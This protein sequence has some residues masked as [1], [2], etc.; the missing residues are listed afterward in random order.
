MHLR[1]SGFVSG[2]RQ[3]TFQFVR[4]PW[5]SYRN[6]APSECYF[7]SPAHGY[8]SNFNMETDLQGVFGA[9]IGAG[10]RPPVFWILFVDFL[11][12][13]VPVERLTTPRWPKILPISLSRAVPI[14]FSTLLLEI[15][16]DNDSFYR[17]PQFRSTFRTEL[18]PIGPLLGLLGFFPCDFLRRNQKEPVLLFVHTSQSRRISVLRLFF[19]PVNWFYSIKEHW[20]ISQLSCLVFFLTQKY[21]L[22][23]ALTKNVTF[24]ALKYAP[25]CAA[26]N[27]LGC[28]RGRHLET[29]DEEAAKALLNHSRRRSP[30]GRK[31]ARESIAFSQ[32]A[33]LIA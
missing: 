24:P 14:A 12:C 16:P 29:G 8:G 10:S 27:P 3:F 25:R 15:S 5:A 23:V 26:H 1:K 20:T 9:R 17:S 19:V 31:Y 13:I 33:S 32:L 4:H 11:F 21:L 22:C 18:H 6:S 28:C 2:Q 30:G 7:R